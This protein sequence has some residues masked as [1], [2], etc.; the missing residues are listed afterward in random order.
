MSLDLIIRGAS[1]VQSLSVEKLS[2]GIADGKIVAVEPDL[3]ER[4]RETI[5]ASGLHLFPGVVDAHV[6]FNDP[7]RAHWEGARTGSAAFAAGGGT[8]FIDMPLNSSPP[9]LDGPSFDAKVEALRGSSYAD[10][11][12]W[13]GLTPKNLRHLEELAER[14]VVGFKAFLANSGIDDF[15]HCDPDSLLF[16]MLEAAKLGLP[17]A[18]HA[19]SDM[20]TATLA[21]SACSAGRTGI[22]DYLE[23]RPIAAE[24]QAIKHAIFAAE[25]AGCSL[26]IVHVSSARGV[27]LVR[28]ASASGKCDVTCETCPHYLLLNDEDVLR[29]SARAKCAPPIRPEAERAA[30]LDRVRAGEVDTIGSDHSPA[31]ADMKT[32]EDFFSVW[33]GISSVQTTLRSLLTLGLPPRLIARLLARRP[34]ARF[35]LPGKGQIR[36]GMDADLTLVDLAVE[37]PLREDELLDRHRL[38]PYVG[39]TFRGAIRRTLLRGRTVSLDGRIVAEPFG[40]LLRPARAVAEVEDA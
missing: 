20:M 1:V 7:G 13:G 22:R 14:G 9:T 16:G 32:S 37:G 8:C 35:R 2:I 29:I 24:E 3:S 4:A 18:V 26:H 12:L 21:Q 10:F 19:E 36:P 25:G 31:P 38:S 39:R 33:G 40:V 11:A 30:L 6:H 23:S 5:D 17:V 27:E 28:Q 34:G 15:Q